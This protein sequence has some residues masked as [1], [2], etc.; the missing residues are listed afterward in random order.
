MGGG[1]GIHT[2]AGPPSVCTPPRA[3][4]GPAQAPAGVVFE[5][6]APEVKL[7]CIS[8]TH[9]IIYL[10]TCLLQ[11]RCLGQTLACTD[12]RLW[13]RGR[14]PPLRSACP[15][16]LAARPW[17]RALL[18]SQSGPRNDHG[19]TVVTEL[20]ATPLPRATPTLM[21][22]GDCSP[23]RSARWPQA[24]SGFPGVAGGGWLIS[25]GSMKKVTPYDQQAQKERWAQ[26]IQH[27]AH[28]PGGPVPRV[29]SA[30]G[31][32]RPK[33]AAG[34]MAGKPRTAQEGAV[35]RGLRASLHQSVPSLTLP[36]TVT[37]PTP[38]MRPPVSPW[39]CCLGNGG[40]CT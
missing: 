31:S 13:R 10:N 18:W 7:S 11:G 15:G 25:T 1:A 32:I 34:R 39:L 33:G 27:S 4:C 30:P 20:A 29:P 8:E 5:M 14:L 23:G 16:P 12:H 3:R 9:Q 40:C 28:A 26:Q 24:G 36:G 38:M 37:P 2:R 6:T 21:D 22:G 35:P 19:L 17:Q